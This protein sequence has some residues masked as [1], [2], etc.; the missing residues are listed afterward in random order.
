MKHQPIWSVPFFISFPKGRN[1]QF[2]ISIGRDMPGNDFSGVQ[3][4]D[5][6][7]VIPFPAGFDIGNVAGPYKIGC[8][9]GKVL[10]QMVTAGDDLRRFAGNVRFV[11]GHL[12]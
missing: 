9:L 6:T 3:I 5:N 10:L 8:F 7:E 11:C 12:G 4:H 1:H 2:P